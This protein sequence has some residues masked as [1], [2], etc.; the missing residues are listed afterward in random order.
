MTNPSQ[1]RNATADDATEAF[2]NQTSIPLREMLENMLSVP[3]PASLSRTLPIDVVMQ[4]ALREMVLLLGRRDED[5][6][7]DDYEVFEEIVGFFENEAE[8]HGDEGTDNDGDNEDR[9][10]S[11]E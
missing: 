5:D 6:D 4:N 7:D 9:N 10:S 3:H 11:A 2:V 8:G 1:N